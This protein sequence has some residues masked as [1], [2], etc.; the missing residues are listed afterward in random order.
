MRHL[1]AAIPSLRLPFLVLTPICVLLGA[2]T[3]HLNG[4]TIDS[5]L[6]LWVMV[7]ALASHISVNTWNEYQDFRHGNDS[8]ADPNPFTPSTTMLPNVPEAANTVMAIAGFSFLVASLVG[9]YFA[10]QLG[11]GILPFGMAGL[12][13]VISYPRWVNRNVLLSLFAPGTGFGLLMVPGTYFALT[14]ELSLSC[15]LVATIPFFL[16]NNLLL[17]NQF[18]DLK[19]DAVI[20]RHHLPRQNGMIISLLVYSLFAASAMVVLYTGIQLAYFPSLSYIA[21]LPL[22]LMLYVIVGAFI[23]K[24]NINEKP[25]YL[26]FNVAVTFL[27]P[28]LLALSFFLI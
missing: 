6:L 14:G 26:G 1:V 22:P 8:E 5:W 13:L 16:S 17:L 7:G 11:M 3:V 23:Y 18:A 20:T 2:A 27:I 21:M 12:L 25:G 19:S 10:K 4:H 9:L 24:E 15:W 28:A